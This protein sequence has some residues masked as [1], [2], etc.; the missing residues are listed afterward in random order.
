VRRSRSILLIT[1]SWL[2][3]QSIVWFVATHFFPTQYPWPNMYRSMFDYWDAWH[4]SAIA[5]EGYSGPVRW[6]FYPL[7]PLIIRFLSRLTLLRMRPDLVGAVFSTFVFLAFAYFQKRITESSDPRLHGLKAETT[8]GWVMFLFWPASWVFHSHHTES[9]FLLLSFAAFMTARYDRWALAAV[10]A[11]LCALTRNQGAFVALAV[12]L[13]SCLL[14]RGY[15][16]RVFVFCCSA[17]ISLVV[18]C[19]WP[20]YQLWSTGNPMM[21][22]LAQQQFLPQIT[23]VHQFFGTIWFANFW[24]HPTW[25]FYLHHVF[26]IVLT[27]SAGFLLWRREYILALYVFL[28]VWVALYL[29]QL[30]NQFRYGATLF[31]A[32]FIMGDMLRRLPWSLRW[33]TFGALVWLNLVCTWDYGVGLWAY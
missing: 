10:L 12:A 18:F 9:L 14:Q 20:L 5:T 30:E 1:A 6:A 33:T 27:I 11:G 24:Q 31:P 22:V 19:P 13:E 21:S 28:S 4:Y 17:L 26:F 29:G 16:R 2:L 15:T 3:V 25:N 32:L 8:W 23:T 7:Y